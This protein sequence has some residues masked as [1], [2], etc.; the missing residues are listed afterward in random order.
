MHFGCVPTMVDSH[1]NLF[2]RNWKKFKLVVY[3]FDEGTF[4]F[5]KQVVGRK[6]SG[7]SVKSQILHLLIA[8]SCIFEKI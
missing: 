1:T 4:S 5:E 6:L 2:E 7:K 3:N 8:L